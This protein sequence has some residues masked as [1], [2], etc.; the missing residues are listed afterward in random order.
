MTIIL[1]LPLKCVVLTALR[2]LYGKRLMIHTKG[3]ISS[4]ESN[5]THDTIDKRKKDKNTNTCLHHSTLLSNIN[6]T[7]HRDLMCFGVVGMFL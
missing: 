7:K 1:C 5:M 6:L 4:R 2:V 3:L